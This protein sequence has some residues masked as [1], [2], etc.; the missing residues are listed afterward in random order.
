ME[1][2]G[3][4]LIDGKRPDSRDAA[5]TTS[6]RARAREGCI[7]ELEKGIHSASLVE[8]GSAHST[9]RG[10][11]VVTLSE[12]SVAHSWLQAMRPLPPEVVEELRHRYEVA[13][14]Y[15]STAIE[16]NTLTQSETQIVLEKGVTIGGKSLAEHLEVIGHKEA[17][18]FVQELA[19]ANTAIGER[20]IRE[21]HS[22]VMKG[23]AN[24]DSG[25]YRNL[26]VMAAGTE[27]RY[28]SHL[29]LPELMAEFV[30]WI[31][32]D[33][34]LHPVVFASEAH[35]RFVTIHPFRDGN[36]R[37]G[38]LLLNLLLLRSGY[39]IAVL[40]VNQRA[41]YIS[42]LEAAQKGGSRDELDALVLEAVGR[43]LR[44]TLETALTSGSVDV[45]E[46][47]RAEIMEWVLG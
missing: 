2:A 26:D 24:E 32:T 8:P 18:D 5:E 28:P 21:V 9:S 10:F 29:H 33:S 37:V 36:G 43:S 42:A 13:L 20:E 22:L 4:A 19:S 25:R 23:L 31:Q 45:S 14:T 46:A 17:L 38:R 34:S 7:Q 1:L 3:L 40:R 39:P 47:T 27:Y 44:E 41:E 16:G 15:H 30:A 35:L 11:A 6:A 12:L